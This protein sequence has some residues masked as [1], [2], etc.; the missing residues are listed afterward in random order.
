MTL[1]LIVSGSPTPRVATARRSAGHSSLPPAYPLLSACHSSITA[2]C[3]EFWAI[4]LHSHTPSTVEK[5]TTGRTTSRLS[6]SPS[7][8]HGVHRP[9][10]PAPTQTQSPSDNPALR[11]STLD[12]SAV[13]FGQFHASTFE[14]NIPV[15][16][17]RPS[18]QHPSQHRTTLA[19]RKRANTSR[20][21]QPHQHPQAIEPLIRCPSGSLSY[22]RAE[23]RPGKPTS[24]LQAN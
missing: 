18:I 6:P 12:T 1:R 5:L 21:D 16:N 9:L 4:T 15:H 19:L 10:A 17:H 22:Q 2:I 20:K 7:S 3:S 13:L 14:C 11:L 8:R 23:F 24:F